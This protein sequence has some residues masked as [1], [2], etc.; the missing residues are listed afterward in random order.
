[1]IRENRYIVLKHSDIDRAQY[2]ID[3]DD[4]HAFERVVMTVAAVRAAREKLPLE[5]VVVESD[6][7]EYE[8]VW[9]MLEKRVD[10]ESI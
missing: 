10:G 4:W 6:W 1:M 2:L 5:A 7:P 8:E 3:E 9:K